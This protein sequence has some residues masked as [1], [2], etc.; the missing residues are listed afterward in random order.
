MDM[1]KFETHLIGIGRL[2]KAATR[3]QGEPGHAVLGIGYGVRRSGRKARGLSQGRPVQ[4]AGRLQIFGND[5][6]DRLQ[7]LLDSAE[8]PVGR[9]RPVW[10]SPPGDEAREWRT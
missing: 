1:T 7:L 9:S 5:D 2:G 10:Q 4:L 6:G 8:S 3:D